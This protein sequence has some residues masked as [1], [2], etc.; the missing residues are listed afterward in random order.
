MTPK[1]GVK[2]KKMAPRIGVKGK[3]KTPKMQKNDTAAVVRLCHQVI[4]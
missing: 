1:N 2:G 3:K 4:L